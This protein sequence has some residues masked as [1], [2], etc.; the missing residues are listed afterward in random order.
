MPYYA[1][2]V[3]KRKVFPYRSSK[4]ERFTNLLVT[5]EAAV[6]LQRTSLFST[7]FWMMKPL[8]LICYC[9]GPRD[10]NTFT[11]FCKLVRNIIATTDMMELLR[12]D[13]STAAIDDLCKRYH[14]TALKAELRPFPFF[15]RLPVVLLFGR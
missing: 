8:V 4:R 12:D 13:P 6:I 7:M 14:V 5:I 15:Y 3:P 11:D 10:E 9:P 2:V 1:S